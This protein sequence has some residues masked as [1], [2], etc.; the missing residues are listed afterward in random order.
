MLAVMPAERRIAIAIQDGGQPTGYLPP[1]AGGPVLR[2][3]G[4]RHTTQAVAISRPARLMLH[5][6]AADV[7][8]GGRLAQRLQYELVDG[9]CAGK[10]L[11]IVP[12][13]GNRRF[14]IISLV[15]LSAASAG[16]KRMPAAGEWT[17][18]ISP[19]TPTGSAVSEQFGDNFEGCLAR[20]K[21]LRDERNAS[22]HI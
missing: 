3:S 4:S 5:S 13:P 2:R 1:P 11:T 20:A 19:K 21:S 8:I 6:L 18:E 17:I 16:G 10:A 15:R 7:T 12:E 22:H 9:E 14:V